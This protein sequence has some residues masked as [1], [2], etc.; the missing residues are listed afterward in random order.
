MNSATNDGRWEEV[1][2]FFRKYCLAKRAHRLAEAEQLFKSTLSPAIAEWSRRQPG[3]MESKRSR[4]NAMFAAEQK[5]LHEA[6]QLKDY[7]S[8]SLRSE[9][10]P[11]LREEIRAMIAADPAKSSTA[12][13][14]ARQ[15]RPAPR[16]RFDDIPG[17]LD[18]VLAE[19]GRLSS[20]F[21]PVVQPQPRPTP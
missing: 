9:I 15:T 17:A 20:S 3:D 19:Q 8:Q 16:I 2:H 5:R 4:L 10:V 14:L 13:S 21:R 12:A 6:W 1:V 11:A 18:R 7:L